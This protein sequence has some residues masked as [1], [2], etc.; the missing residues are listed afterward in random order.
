VCALAVSPQR[1]CEDP[2]TWWFK[3]TPRMFY[4]SPIS[5]RICS[6]E[7]AAARAGSFPSTVL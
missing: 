7:I 5:A 6:M 3:G 1:G 4:S 2:Q